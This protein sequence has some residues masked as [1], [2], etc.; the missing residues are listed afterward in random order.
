MSV[1]VCFHK[2]RE[3]ENILMEKILFAV[4]IS[5][6]RNENKSGARISFLSLGLGASKLS[7]TS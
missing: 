5:Q 4:V 2:I 7:R 6:L 1:I 3:R